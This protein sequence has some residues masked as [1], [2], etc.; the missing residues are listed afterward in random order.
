[1]TKATTRVG[2]AGAGLIFVV[3]DNATLGEF[4]KIVLKGDGYSVQSFTD[5]THVLQAMAAAEPKPVALVTDYD[6]GHMNGLELIVSSH[7]IHPGLK[8][9]LLSGTINGEF[10]SQH[11]ARVDRFLGKPYQATELK[12]IVGQLLQS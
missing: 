2:L 4:A 12:T 6:M 1:M 8:T 9:V 3:D 5:P 10:I 7:K 11:P